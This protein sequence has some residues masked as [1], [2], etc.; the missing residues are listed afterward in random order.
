M[1][2]LSIIFTILFSFFAYLVLHESFIRLLTFKI[3]EK[4]ALQTIFSFQSNDTVNCAKKKKFLSTFGLVCLFDGSMGFM[5]DIKIELVWQKRCETT[6]CNNKS[7]QIRIT[8]NCLLWLSAIVY[9]VNAIIGLCPFAVCNFKRIFSTRNFLVL[10]LSLFLKHLNYVN[11]FNVII[12]T[13]RNMECF[14]YKVVFIIM[15][16]RKEFTRKS[17]SSGP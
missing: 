4:K 6:R 5:F 15:I 16:Q 8:N 10:F 1:E 17:L 9:C 13:E 2:M 7:V 14:S 12:A 3:N 11:E